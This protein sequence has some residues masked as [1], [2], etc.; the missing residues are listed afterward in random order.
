MKHANKALGFVLSLGM[1]FLAGTGAALAQDKTVSIGYQLMLNPWKVAIA[2]KRFEEATGW[3]IE[4][5]RFGS[6]GKVVTALASGAIAISSAGSSPIATAVNRGVDVQLIYILEDIAAAEAIVV[7][8][9][10]GI[11]KP[12]D[13]IGK[14]IGVTFVS[15]THYQLLFALDHWGIDQDQV[16]ILNLQPNQIAAA[17][18]RGDICAAF[19]WNPALARIKETGSVLTTS[20]E[21]CELGRCTFDGLVV[22]REFAEANPEFMAQFVKVIEEVT[23]DYRKNTAEWT[24][25]SPMAEK[26]AELAGAPTEIVPESLELYAFPPIEEQASCAWLDCGAEGGAVQ[27]LLYTS[28]YLKDQGLVDELKP[29]YGKFVTPVYAQEAMKLM[30]Q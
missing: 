26:I 7:R 3:N 15:T 11:E 29:D 21:L 10:C 4:W 19:I 1:V 6:G 17:W 28:Q 16:E 18:L 2:D 8:D 5:H 25:D 24:A 12:K 30:K 27:A 14:K 22:Q 20:G 23:A 13:L 9:G